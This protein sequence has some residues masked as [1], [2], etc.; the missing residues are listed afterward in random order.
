MRMSNRS[1]QLQTSHRDNRG[2]GAHRRRK[3]ARPLLAA[4]TVIGGAGIV[5]GAPA[6]ALFVG[7]GVAQ[8]APLVS[9][10][11]DV[12]ASGLVGCTDPSASSLSSTGTSL[13][14]G[15]AALSAIPAGP[16]LADPFGLTNAFLDL[17][18]AIP[19]L[20]LFIGNGADGTAAHPDGFNGGLF[21]GSGGNGYSPTT[22]GA[23]G[24]NGGNGGL[25]MGNGGAGGAGAN[26]NASVGGGN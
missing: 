8:A 7:S 24:G 12:C 14:G 15:G 9:A 4:A 18:G 13:F 21:A 23:T 1:K 3:P 2:A 17:A 19:G 5:L 6:A 22:A 26:G 16:G 20:N 10:P 11:T 25:F